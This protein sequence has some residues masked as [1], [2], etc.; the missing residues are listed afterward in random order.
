MNQS[1]ERAWKKGLDRA[2]RWRRGQDPT[3]VLEALGLALVLEVTGDLDVRPSDELEPLRARGTDAVRA[4]AEVRGARDD[5]PEAR[6]WAADLARAGLR[7]LGVTTKSGARRAPADVLHPQHARLLRMLRG[8]LDGLAAGACATHVLSCARCASAVRVLQMSELPV[9]TGSGGTVEEGWMAVAA[10]PRAP[11]R[12]PSEGRLVARLEDQRVEAILF[13][14]H[15]AQRVGV[16]AADPL[17]IRLAGERVTTEHM[18]PGYFL[19]RIDPR[20][21][22]L[23]ATLHIGEREVRWRIPVGGPRKKK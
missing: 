8:E 22:T 19:G 18:L 14:D 11:M 16:Y 21:K 9:A 2:A 15:G 23:D 6:R 13:E 17:P 4:A 5:D 1:L 20:G 7:V 10:S 12:P 3:P